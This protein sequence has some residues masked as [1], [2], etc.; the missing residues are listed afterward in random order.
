[1]TGDE[2]GVI[3]NQKTSQAIKGD[4][5]AILATLGDF[6]SADNTV[7]D[8]LNEII[9]KQNVFDDDFYIECGKHYTSLSQDITSK[10]DVVFVDVK[11][12]GTIRKLF[13]GKSLTGT[14]YIDDEIFITSTAN[15]STGYSMEFGIV[16]VESTAIYKLGDILANS[17][18][19]AAALNFKK[20]FKIVVRDVLGATASDGCSVIYGIGGA[21]Q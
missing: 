5:E 3:A 4:T 9:E 19:T 13:F 12:C 14:V 7:S 8:K 17:K 2:L 16:N 21:A 10:T 11:G 20:S 1:M 18:F 15:N 6:A